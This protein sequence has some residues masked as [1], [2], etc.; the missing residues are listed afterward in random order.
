MSL[1]MERFRNLLEEILPRNRF[2]HQA[3]AHLKLDPRDFRTC[4]DLQRLPFTTKDDL[5]EDQRLHPPYGNIL[6]YPRE[7]Y[8]RLHQTSGTTSGKA[9]CWLDTPNSWKH[10]LSC[11]HDGFA[12]MGIRSEDV[13]FFPFSFGPFLGFWSAFEAASTAGN[14]CIA[15]G[16]MSSTARLRLLLDHEAT[17][18]CCTPTYALHLSELADREGIDLARSPVRAVIVAG[19]PGGNIPSTRARIEKVWGARLFDHYGMTEIGPV[20]MERYESANTMVI[21]TQHYIAEVVAPDG[22]EWVQPGEVGELVL[23]NLG[24]AG[25]PLVRY[26]TGDL[27]RFRSL[28]RSPANSVSQAENEI[29]M[30]G[31]V[32]GRTDDMIHIRGNNLYPSSME[33]VI[34]RFP[35]VLE[36]RLV[37]DERDPLADLRIEIE[38]TEDTLAPDLV[39][40]VRRAVRDELLFRVEVEAVPRG[41]LPRFEMK[42][43][44]IH[45]IR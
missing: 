3:Y 31:G 26:R 24:R 22:S 1:S 21:L 41:T 42:A 37:I 9:L 17:I 39:D 5:I 43:R 16:G 28:P 29:T 30:D 10:L 6:T 40:A 14:L 4:E 34:R 12:C 7:K 19:E 8:S 32:L 35:E 23:T 38:A 44:R 27:V 25:S 13:F 2:Y 45:K 18:V 15:G 11:W 36:F 33:A 20:A